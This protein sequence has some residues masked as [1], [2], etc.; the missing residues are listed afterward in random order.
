MPSGGRI[1][2]AKNPGPDL[3]ASAVQGDD[4]TT[5]RM[6]INLTSLQAHFTGLVDRLKSEGPERADLVC[7]QE[8]SL[9]EELQKGLCG[10][11]K[12]E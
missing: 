2:E 11:A 8:H 12:S 10:R 9:R 7:F 5:V 6:S 4:E 1:G 3:R